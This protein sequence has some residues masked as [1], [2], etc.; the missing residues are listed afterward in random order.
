MVLPPKSETSRPSSLERI[1]RFEDERGL[2]GR[3]VDRLGDEQPLD[4]ELPVADAAAQLFEEDAL[5]Q[6]VLVDDEHPLGCFEDEVGV[7]DLH[8]GAQQ[9]EPLARS[10]S[11]ERAGGLSLLPLPGFAGRGWG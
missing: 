9:E 10:A 8:G 4:F 5:V 6:G 1:G 11:P 7:L 3:Q 2:L